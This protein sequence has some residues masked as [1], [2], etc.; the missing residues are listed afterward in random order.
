MAPKGSSSTIIPAVISGLGVLILCFFAGTAVM[1]WDVF[2]GPQVTKAFR[3]GEALYSK[4]TAYSS[5]FPTAFWNPQRTDEEGVTL[6]DP[7]RAL[8][9]W[10]LYSS[11]HAQEAILVDM[12]G[13][14]VHR[15]HLPFHE[16]WDETAVV[17][18]IRE[19]SDIQ[20]RKAHMYPNGDLLAIYE[21]IGETPWGYGLVKM[22]KDG[23]VIWKFLEQA[24]HDVAVHED[25][26]VYVLTH[27]M[28]EGTMQY[29]EHLTPPR[30]DD[31]LV[32]LSEDGEV[33]ARVDIMQALANSRYRRVLA[34]IPWYL[35]GAGDYL[36]TNALDIV[37]AEDAAVFPYAEEGDV[38]LSIREL[39]MIAVLDI[40]TATIQWAITGAWLG[41]HDADIM[42]DGTIMMFDNNG[43]FDEGGQSRVIEIDPATTGITWSFHGDEEFFFQSTIRS[44]QQPLP[45]GNVLIT[46]SNPGRLLEVTR[47]GDVVWEYWN[48]ERAVRSEEP[49][50]AIVC[51]GER[52]TA[53][54]LDP[55][56][57]E[58]IGGAPA[59][60]T[61]APEEG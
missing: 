2:P 54:Q 51:W 15:W 23:E 37:T 16:V 1:Y 39:N 36:H 35:Q 6:H 58:T 59:G 20:I 17:Q 43:H 25:G 33:L 24:H 49:I 38:L 52:F 60:S 46:E 29:L 22:N 3:A 5:E 48:P 55:E 12:A 34:S 44:A 13:N 53:D 50:I 41:Q 40:E 42:P 9:G 61:E 30:I 57:L 45:N 8:E 32:I 26:R 47:G 19:P 31:L 21:A 11:G 14:A 56:F 18:T 4:L 28:R 27:E 7:E 10:T